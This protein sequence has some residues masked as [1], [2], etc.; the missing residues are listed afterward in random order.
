MAGLTCAADL[1][2]LDPLNLASTIRTLE[3]QGFDELH[4]DIADGHFV[5]RYGFALDVI[6]AAKQ[7]TDL[8]CH[9]HLL[10]SQPEHMLP[11][12]LAAGADI[13]TLHLETCIHTHRALS[14]IRDAGARAGI[15]VNPA[16]SLTKLNYL[17][18]LTDRL[19][20]VGSHRSA[21]KS[22]MPRGTFERI[23][24]LRE[25]LRYHEYT[26]LLEVEG[27]LRPEDAA[28]CARFG[29]SQLVVDIGSLPGIANP[30][31]P[32]ALQDYRS[33]I[34]ATAQIV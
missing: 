34:T 6:A 22:T 1:K 28:R 10:V 2:G 17:L 26:A 9:V 23:K 15:A 8:P 3:T 16:T 7:I 5:P 32:G 31:Q 24:I 19:L 25:N 20:L 13:V 18:P 33:E 27:P 21:P 12:I 14:A 30:E 4:F 29:A 11:E